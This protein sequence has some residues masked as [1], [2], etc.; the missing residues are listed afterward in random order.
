MSDYVIVEFTPVQ[1][2]L[3]IASIKEYVKAVIEKP[4]NANVLED[5]KRVKL[6]SALDR[7]AKKVYNGG[8]GGIIDVEIE[9]P[10]YWFSIGLHQEKSGISGRFI[11]GMPYFQNEGEEQSLPVKDF[12]RRCVSGYNFLHPK[13]GRSDGDKV[14]DQQSIEGW[15]AFPESVTNI[16]RNLEHI[17][18]LN[19]YG[20]DI[21]AKIGMQKFRTIPYGKLEE[22]ADGGVLLMR[23]DHP[24]EYSETRYMEA[25]RRHLFGTKTLFDKILGR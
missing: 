18:W 21:I 2:T 24:N 1:R 3:D 16:E 5:N 19:F 15:K 7:L 10:R 23:G 20:P 25:I 9:N 4:T 22:L 8:K 6:E 17:F 13:Y 14:F 11:I 12:I